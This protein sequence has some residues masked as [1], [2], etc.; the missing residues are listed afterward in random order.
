MPIEVKTLRCSADPRG[1]LFEPLDDEE[2]ARQRN[3][4]V[5]L[6]RPGQVRGN[7]VHHRTTEWLSVAGPALVRVRVEGEVQ[8]YS[9]P[10][11][12]AHRFTIPPEVAHAIRNT[13]TEWGLCVSFT[14]QVH[15]PAQPDVSRYPLLEPTH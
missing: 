1:W 11:G 12:E 2:L 7:H 9:V 5:V 8:D 15:D 3:V 13:G 10:G 6:T 14:D 4:H